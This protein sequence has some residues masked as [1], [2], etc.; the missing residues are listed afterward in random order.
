MSINVDH[1]S[2]NQRVRIL[3]SF[4]DASGH[5]FSKGEIGRIRRIRLDWATMR[6]TIELEQ[7]ADQGQTVVRKIALQDSG[8]LGDVPRAGNLSDYFAVEGIEFAA[9]PEPSGPD[10][11]LKALELERAGNL[12]EAEAWI[13]AA[14]PDLQYAMQTAE[15]YK[16]RWL[17]L[18]RAGDTGEGQAPRG[19]AQ[20]WAWFF[21]SMA[22]SGSEGMALSRER[23]QFLTTLGRDP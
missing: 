20:E 14:I 9:V 21:A 17:R 19:K 16:Q 15:L 3:K 13:A 6:A 1:L 11:W 12:P 10:W 4:V 2:A 22:T 23:D 8:R 18:T 7:P 5:S